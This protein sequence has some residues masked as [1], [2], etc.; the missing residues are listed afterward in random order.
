MGCL[1]D[2]TSANAFLCFYNR[3]LLEKCPANLNQFFIEDMFKIFL[4]YSYQPII[5]RNFVSPLILITRI[6]IFTYEKEKNDKISF[7]NIEILRGNS[8]F[9]TTF[10]SVRHT[11]SSFCTYLERFLASAHTFGMLYALICMCFTLCS[12]WIDFHRELVTFK[13]I[14]PKKWLSKTSYI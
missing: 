2:P 14:F 9:V 10:F 3:K 12:N 7:L 1:I 8:K 6:C 11:F 13:K 4:F 5:L